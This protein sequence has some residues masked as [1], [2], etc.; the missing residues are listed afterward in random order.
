MRVLS[1]RVLSIQEE[2]RRNISR[3]LHDDIG[4]SLA[5]LKIGLYRLGQ[6]PV[7]EQSSLLAEC[8]AAA[9]ETIEKLRALSLELRPPQLDQLG[10]EDALRWLVERQRNATG[11]DIKCHFNGLL[12]KRAPAALETV[13]YRIVQEALNNATRHA[14][15]KS[16]MIQVEANARLLRFTVHDDGAGFDEPAARLRALHSGSF[17][18]ISMEERAHLAGGRLR[19]RTVPG[20]G[21]TITA[22]FPLDDSDPILALGF[23]PGLRPSVVTPATPIRDTS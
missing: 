23:A 6:R 7:A 2:E 22:M 14:N 16:I 11:L 4:Q 8:V 21:T 3:E 12:K 13:C 20:G 5:A 10:M 17:G 18:L 1:K 19:L 15:A 9:D